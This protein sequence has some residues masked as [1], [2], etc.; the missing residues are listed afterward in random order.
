[1][2]AGLCAQAQTL[3]WYT[4][5]ADAF[6][7]AAAAGQRVLLI[8]GTEGCDACEYAKSLC[9]SPKL[10][11]LVSSEYATWYDDYLV[12]SE[13]REYW[14]PGSYSLPLLSIIDPNTPTN[15]AYPDNFLFQTFGQP[16]LNTFSNQLYHYAG[17]TNAVL[18]PCKLSQ[19]KPQINISC[20]TYGATVTVQ[21]S[22]ALART[23]TVWQTVESFTNSA[24]KT[25]TFVD[26]NALPRA[27]YRV[28][29]TR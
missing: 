28:Y 3:T 9:A 2:L 29:C 21:R 20:L 13:Y 18:G 8:V 27:L 14:Q 16:V 6:K 22:T 11:P 17:F 4:N 5:K 24:G 26:T 15:T 12:S 10:Y 1:V 23:N 7:A 25:H 19:G